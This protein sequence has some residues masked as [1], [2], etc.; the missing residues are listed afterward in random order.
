MARF[1][2][3]EEL[4]SYISNHQE[5]SVEEMSD[6][7]SVSKETVRRDL[8]QLSKEKKVI[9]TRGGAVAIDAK[10]AP[11]NRYFARTEINPEAKRCIAKKVNEYIGECYTLG[12]D[13]S[14]TTFEAVKLLKDNEKMTVITNSA[15]ACCALADAEF[16]IASTGGFL[17]K[18]TLAYTGTQAKSAL[19]NYNIDIALISCTGLS[20]GAGFTDSVEDDACLL[21]TSR[22]V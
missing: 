3:I 2:R 15:Y 14:T 18:S 1:N 10:S 11:D 21:Y 16:N 17:D 19:D 6:Y 8:K 22:C 13:S 4:S 9:R 5:A 7:F 12:F 20:R